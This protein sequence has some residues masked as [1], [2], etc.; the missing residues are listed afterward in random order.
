MRFR[1]SDE[2]Q[3]HLSSQR[4]SGLSITA[5]CKRENIAQQTFFNWRKRQQ[6]RAKV[7][8]HSSSSPI[9]F[10]QIPAQ[11]PEA[12]QFDLVLPNGAH[13]TMP[14]SCDMMFLRQAVRLLAPLR[15]R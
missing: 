7:K 14:L 9:S 12:R 5:Y 15:P 2:I 6:N 4:T 3:R 1:T 11:P 8:T 13:L 10:L